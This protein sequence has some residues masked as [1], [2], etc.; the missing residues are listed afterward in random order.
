VCG[1]FGITAK[2]FPL[3]EEVWL[4]SSI[5]DA[6]ALK[7]IWTHNVEDVDSLKALY[8]KIIPFVDKGKRSI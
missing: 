2:N 8:E 6:K 1:F 7:Y 5:G 4:K 3:N